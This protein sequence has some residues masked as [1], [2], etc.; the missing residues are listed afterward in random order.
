MSTL[1]ERIIIAVVRAVILVIACVFAYNTG[2]AH[3]DS[4]WQKQ[5]VTFG[6]YHCA[7]EEVKP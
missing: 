4:W 7:C 1:R 2:K 3:A 5:T 6:D